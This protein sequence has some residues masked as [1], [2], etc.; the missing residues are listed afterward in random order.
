[1]AS[2]HPLSLSKIMQSNMNESTR[3]RN[4]INATNVE[5]GFNI[6]THGSD[7]NIG[8]HEVSLDQVYI[9][10]QRLQIKYLKYIIFKL[11]LVIRKQRLQLKY[12]KYV[13]LKLLLV[14]V[15][16]KKPTNEERNNNETLHAIHLCTL[17][18]FSSKIFQ[19]FLVGNNVRTQLLQI[20]KTLNSRK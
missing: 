17:L 2:A 20:A 18:L 4:H 16:L 12:L 6:E 3:E 5:K 11:L 14:K 1:M 10:K 19:K 9:R 15:N 13:I 7:M 8:V